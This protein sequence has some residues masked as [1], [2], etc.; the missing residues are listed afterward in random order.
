MKLTPVEMGLKT[1]SALISVPLLPFSLFSVKQNCST[2]ITRFGKVDRVC[3][4]GLRWAP[5]FCRRYE[6]FQGVQT[7]K[8][9]NMHIL[10]RVGTPIV[11]SANMNYK[12]KVPTEYVVNIFSNIDEEKNQVEYH[13]RVIVNMSENSIRKG[14][15]KRIF[16]S[17]NEPDIRKDIDNV[18]QT[19]LQD[20]NVHLSQFGIEV[21]SVQIT[22]ANYAPEIMNQ[23]LVKQQSLAYIEGRTEL[24]KG[25]LGI[26]ED[27]VKDMP[28]LS[29]ET[30]EKIIVNLLTIL[31][32]QSAV[33]PVI[34]V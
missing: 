22:E 21:F 16:V 23:M 28:E 5:L 34:K 6:I 33:Q 7:K 24:V 20:M 15:S 29:K 11:V 31:T 3:E 14:I 13:E 4:P 18:S 25:S 9:S 8:F 26:I 17:D 12:I 27:T 2:V 1:L 30:K 19:I 32:S 10:D